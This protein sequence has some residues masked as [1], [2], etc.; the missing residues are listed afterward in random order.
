MFGNLRFVML[1]GGLCLLLEQVLPAQQRGDLTMQ[2]VYGG[3]APTQSA[4]VINKDPEFCGKFKILDE[5]LVVD[6][7]TGGIANV[8]V[9]LTV[10]RG[11]K[12]PAAPPGDPDAAATIRIDNDGCRFEPHVT[13]LRTTQKLVVGNKDQIAHNVKVDFFA[14]PPINPI[15]PASAVLPPQQFSLEERLPAKASCSIHPWMAGWIVVKDHP[16]MGVSDKTGKLVIRNLPVGPWSFQV[17]HE[18]A[19]YL[20]SV[21]LGG[22]PAT[23][24]KGRVDVTIAANA[25][26]MV[27]TVP[28]AAFEGK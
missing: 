11:A 8:V 23:W 27:V 1:V 13:L 26:P 4:A 5:S 20:S 3:K 21:S 24:P 15:L 16:Y 14:N 6:G 10:A 12:A 2:F 7:A 28:A 19:G 25:P 22:K 9:Y 18:K 17:W